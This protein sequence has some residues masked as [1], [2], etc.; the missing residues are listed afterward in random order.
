MFA[1]SN[2]GQSHL[3]FP[4]Q[5]L[6][7]CI[8]IILLIDLLSSLVC[9]ILLKR[10]LNLHASTSVYDD[11]AEATCADALLASVSA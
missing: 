9:E 2:L 1:P 4:C 6:F 5:Y 8:S 7:L 10:S 3:I 11:S